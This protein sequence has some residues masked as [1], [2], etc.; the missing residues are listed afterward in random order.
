MSGGRV[1]HDDRKPPAHVDQARGIA[2]RLLAA[3]ETAGMD[4]AAVDRHLA[5]AIAEDPSLA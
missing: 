2:L 4:L 3:I 5:R 1:T